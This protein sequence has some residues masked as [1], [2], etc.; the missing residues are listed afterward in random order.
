MNDID[1]SK[2]DSLSRCFLAEVQKSFP[3]QNLEIKLTDRLEVVLKAKSPE[4]GN[5]HVWLDGD[6]VTVGIGDFYHTHFETYLDNTVP[7]DEAESMAVSESINFIKRKERGQ[8]DKE[9][10]QPDNRKGKGSA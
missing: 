6:E 9:R 2:L 7:K 3:D 5:I 1:L 8:P 10:G 4:F